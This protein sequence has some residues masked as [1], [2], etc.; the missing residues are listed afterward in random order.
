MAGP[1]NKAKGGEGSEA[2]KVWTVDSLKWTGNETR[3]WNGL[4]MR[5]DSGMD[6]E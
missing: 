6:W 1:G 2:I 3:Q 5:L 4:G